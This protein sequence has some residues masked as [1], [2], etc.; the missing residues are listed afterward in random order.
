MGSTEIIIAGDVAGNI[1]GVIAGETCLAP[2]KQLIL[3]KLTME[4]P[5]YSRPYS[6][7]LR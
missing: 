6:L 2:T 5:R 4:T 1:A 7:I 3:N